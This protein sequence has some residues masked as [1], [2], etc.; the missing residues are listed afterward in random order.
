MAKH[1]LRIP[2][3]LQR[4]QPRQL[5]R[6]ERVDRILVPVRIADVDFHLGEPV[7]LDE[8]APQVHRQ[9][10]RVRARGARRAAR[11]GHFEHDLRVD[12]PPGISGGVVRDGEDGLGGEE[13][14][15]QNGT[16]RF[17]VLG[18]HGAVFVEGVNEGGCGEVFDSGREAGVRF[19]FGAD[20]G[21]EGETGGFE[22]TAPGEGVDN[23][24][25]GFEVEEW[26][27][28]GHKGSHGA[29]VD[30]IKDDFLLLNG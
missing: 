10:V 30:G 29:R 3:I 22:E 8:F 28:E 18:V 15:L 25:D 14:D 12:G 4:D 23:L 19:S 16:L 2:Q 24:D 26:F 13:F 20:A 7:R 1:I 11:E 27:D 6:P 9:R 5:L 21:V 17:R